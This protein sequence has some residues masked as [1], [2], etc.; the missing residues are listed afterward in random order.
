M[1][2][3]V[4]Q[5]TE[6]IVT[7]AFLLLFALT[8][9]NADIW[10]NAMT[11]GEFEVGPRTFPRT[12]CL[13]SCTLMLAIL[14]KQIKLARLGLLAEIEEGHEPTT[15]MLMLSLVALCLVY[16]WAMPKVG[17]IVASLFFLPSFLLLVGV[18]RPMT[19]ILFTVGVFL[20]AFLFFCLL[21][22]LQ[23]PR[24]TGIFKTFSL[25]FY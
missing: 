23:L 16:V 4:K 7:C 9:V 14:L 13:I 15:Y 3:K 2:D 19:I 25:L 17:F 12:V 22:K 11:T 1:L 6:L 21:M 18:R 8:F 20:V 5:N 10:I 24:G